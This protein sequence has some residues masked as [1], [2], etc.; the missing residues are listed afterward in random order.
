MVD[1]SLH[2]LFKKNPHICPE[3]TCLIWLVGIHSSLCRTCISKDPF[4]EVHLWTDPVKIRDY[5]DDKQLLMAKFLRMLAGIVKFQLEGFSNS[6]ITNGGMKRLF[7]WN[8]YFPITDT[9]TSY[10]DHSSSFE[11]LTN[12]PELQW[13]QLHLSGFM[14]P[15]GSGSPRRGMNYEESGESADVDDSTH[16]IKKTWRQ[17]PDELSVPRELFF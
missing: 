4:W 1:Q 9:L 14:Q 6:M 10:Y 17:S 15:E 2:W 13:L 8:K 5:E 12:Y 7:I 16:T 3:R 11:S